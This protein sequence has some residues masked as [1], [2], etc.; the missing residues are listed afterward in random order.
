[1]IHDTSGGSLCL[2]GLPEHLRGNFEEYRCENCISKNV[3]GFYIFTKDSRLWNFYSRVWNVVTD[4]E[5]VSFT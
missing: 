4:K 1:M 5:K 2:N 3:A